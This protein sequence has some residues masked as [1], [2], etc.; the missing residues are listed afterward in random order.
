MS[1]VL[2]DNDVTQIPSPN[3]QCVKTVITEVEIVAEEKNGYVVS[4]REESPKTGKGPFRTIIR[5]E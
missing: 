4:H 2:R 5:N 1:E 3:K